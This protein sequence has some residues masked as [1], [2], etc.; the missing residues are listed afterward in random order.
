METKNNLGTLVRAGL[1]LFT[2]VAL[3]TLLMFGLSGC[4]EAVVAEQATCNVIKLAD[5]VCT[6][7]EVPDEKGQVQQ[8][9]VA[10]EDLR[11]LARKTA[12][13]RK[14]DAGRVDNKD[15]SK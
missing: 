6:L 9:P 13:I 10:A 14:L 7:V 2:F 11:E 1:V 8:V 4:P 5:K 15:S 12:A 3:P